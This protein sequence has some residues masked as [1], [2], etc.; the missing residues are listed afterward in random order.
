[1]LVEKMDAAINED[2]L[3]I[4]VEK[5]EFENMTYLMLYFDFLL[6]HVKSR[7]HHFICN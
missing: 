4:V 7:L 3:K 5:M 1:M 6:L 2:V